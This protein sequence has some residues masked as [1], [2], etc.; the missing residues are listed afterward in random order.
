MG[1]LKKLMFWKKRSLKTPT[2]VDAI[3]STED[4]QTSDDLALTMDQT[5]VDVCVSEDPRITEASTMNM[6]PIEVDEYVSTEEPKK[7][8]RRNNRKRNY[9]TPTKVDA[10]VQQRSTDQRCFSD[11]GPDQ[12]GCMCVHRV[13]TDL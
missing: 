10:C 5:E 1:F 9:K 4:P 7:K 6:E 11:Y 2:K 13:S 8:R 3:V 12:G